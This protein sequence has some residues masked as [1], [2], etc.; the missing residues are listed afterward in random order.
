ML[1][2]TIVLLTL[3]LCNFS[4]NAQLNLTGKFHVAQISASC[5]KYIN[6]GGCMI[7]NY[8]VMKFDKDSVE[9]SYPQVANC[10]TK[11]NE[12][13]YPSNNKFAKKHKWII[14]ANKLIIND[15]K[16]INNYSF[17]EKSADYVGTL[18]TN[19]RIPNANKENSTKILNKNSDNKLKKIRGFVFDNS[20]FINTQIP[21]VE[22]EVKIIGTDRKTKTDNDGKFEIEA[23]IGEEM[24]IKGLGTKTKEILI[25]DS[26]CYKINLD[27]NILDDLMAISK[28][29]ARKLKR[30]LL[31]IQQN[32]K[33]KI[34]EGFYDCTE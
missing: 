23:K 8:C 16:E 32:V 6:G 11:E 26:N 5:E 24:F 22:I 17:E 15:F 33:R 9:I 21:A 30:K 12:I 18:T 29:D 25:D 2:K 19:N 14:K 4:L 1:K 13:N 27:T 31:K 28:K 34:A 3:F 10:S 20:Y 7:Y